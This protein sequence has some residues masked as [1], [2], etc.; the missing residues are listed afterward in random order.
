MSANYAVA[1][2]YLRQL[3]QAAQFNAEVLWLAIRVERRV[4]NAIGEA[5]YTQ[6]LRKNFPDSKE[7]AA[8]QAGQF[9]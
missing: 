3:A 8:L 6:Q 1:Q 4:G 2:G 7:A 5:S 9:E